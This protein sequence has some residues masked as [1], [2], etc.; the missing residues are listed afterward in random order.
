MLVLML[1]TKYNQVSPHYLTTEV[2][3][4]KAVRIYITAVGRL[5]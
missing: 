2:L 4:M 5:F 1:K 3:Q